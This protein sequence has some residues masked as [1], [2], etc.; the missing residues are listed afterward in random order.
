VD[1]GVTFKELVP[2]YKQLR[3]VLLTHVHSDHFKE[4]TIRALA[5]NRPTLRFG[6]CEWLVNDLIECGVKKSNIDV[7]EI[8]NTYDYGVCT[9][10]PVKLTHNVPNCGYKLHFSEDKVIY[11]TDTNDLEGIEAKGYDLYLIENNY[12]DEE[13]QERIRQKEEQGIYPYELKVMENH[14]SKTKCDK[15]INEN[16]SWNSEYHYMHQHVDKNKHE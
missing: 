3:L 13:I 1:C 8:D 10:T 7:F 6:C 11:C 5:Y 4:R 9:V 14:L 16:S 12:E 2:Y 15:F